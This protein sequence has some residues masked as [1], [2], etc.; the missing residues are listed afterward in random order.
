MLKRIYLLTCS[1]LLGGMVI[2]AQQKIKFSSQNYLGFIE[3]EAG[4]SFQLHSINGLKYKTWFA[5]IGAGLDYY[6]LRS[7]PVFFSVN[8]FLGEKKRTFFVSGDAGMSF[9]WQKSGDFYYYYSSAQKYTPS[10]YWAQSIG[11]KI[12][13]RGND[14]LLFSIGYSYKKLKGVSEY[15]LPCINPPCPVNKE[16]YEYRLKRISVKAGWMF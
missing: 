16:R 8:K 1:F 6:Y 5:G 11:Y 14:A 2:Y 12:G 7:V 3:G 10:L 9:P 13:F 15:E 4:T